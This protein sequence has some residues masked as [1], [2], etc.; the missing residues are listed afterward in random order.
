MRSIRFAIT[1][2][3]LIALSGC[4]TT[5]KPAACPAGT[6]DLPGCPP[7]GAISDAFIDRLYTER[8]WVPGN[9]LTFDPIEVGKQAEIPIQHAEA[10]FLGG[11]A[12]DALNSLAAKIW[13]IDN[14]QHTVD[15]TYYIFKR[16]LVGESLL[17]ALCNAVK[18][19]VDVRFMVDSIGSMDSNHRGLKALET[20]ADDAGFIRNADG[21]LT[22]RKARVQVVIFN[23]ISKIF[24]NANRRSHDKFLIVD[25]SFPGRAM[26]MTGGRNISLS[27]YGILADGSPNPDTYMDAEILLRTP[28]QWTSD[29]DTVGEVSESYFTL[30]FFF[31]N[32]LRLRPARS[33]LARKL[34]E[35]IQQTAQDRLSELKAIPSMQERLEAMPEY[36]ASDWTKAKV[37][38]AHEFGNLTNRDV[39]NDPVEKIKQN[40]NSIQHFL[41]TVAYQDATHV[42]FVSPY[43]FSPEFY[44][45]DGNEILDGARDV[46]RWLEADPQRTIEIITNS[47]LTSDNFP[48]QSVIDMNMAPRMLLPKDWQEAWMNRREDGEQNASLVGGEDW[49]KLIEHP[50]LFIYETGRLDDR[51]IGGDVD[52][53]KLHSKY[54]IMDD[55][56]FVGTTN[57]DHRSRL[58]NNEMG[59]FLES[60]ELT[61]R[62]NADFDLLKSRSYRWGSPEWLEMRQRLFQA[63]GIKANT[64]KSQRGIY[65]F[66]RATGIDKQL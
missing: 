38:L 34:Y 5:G 37:L 39:F 24:V 23:A 43:L 44:D 6:Q 47:V 42:R 64:A 1:F 61:R 18:R 9:E 27:Y 59:F 28:A 45:S 52:Y 35:E 25:G 29:A 40:P 56:G 10:K 22:T 63:R 16:D 57:F 48:A 17:G 36:M 50:R 12:E 8:T 58:L 13:M 26:A 49:K 60:E 54:I 3:L 15:A 21:Q 30:L 20:C 55:G 65:K 7:A 11:T 4:A 2:S 19:G 66:L 31:Q 51:L 46:H 32:N 41:A 53:G 14:A 62:M 33:S